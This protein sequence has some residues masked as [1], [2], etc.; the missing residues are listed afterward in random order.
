MSRGSVSRFMRAIR[1]PLLLLLPVWACRSLPPER[2]APSRAT[3][4]VVSAGRPDH[5]AAWPEFREGSYG[6]ALRPSLFTIYGIDGDFT[7]VTAVPPVSES[8]H[9]AITGRFGLALAGEVFVN[10]R[11]SLLAGVDYR[12]YEV[13]DLSPLKPTPGGTQPPD[14][15]L[16]PIQSIQYFVGARYAFDPIT[17]PDFLLDW[18]PAAALRPFIQ[19]TV[20]Y[21]PSIDIDFETDLS[22][23][24]MSNIPVSSKGDP[25]WMAALT[26][27]LLYR[28]RDGLVA[29]LG[30]VYETPLVPLD[31][32]LPLDLGVATVSL[33]AELE[34]RGLI[35]YFGLTWYP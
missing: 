34:P 22:S 11:V 20:S 30:L 8:D 21:L 19:L 35:G 3:Q 2:T 6:I 31:A 28:W 16:D 17:P 13:D 18:Q 23:F 10:E 15:I 29:E 14:L 5:A 32:D 12:V 7:N 1:L 25:F 24:G 33:E 27:G 26:G 9:S 4:G